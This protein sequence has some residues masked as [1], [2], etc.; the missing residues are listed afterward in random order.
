MYS[1]IKISFLEKL[2]CKYA[3]IVEISGVSESTKIECD[4]RDSHAL[5]LIDAFPFN[6]N[7]DRQYNVI[8]ITI[9]GLP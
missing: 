1:R 4:A 3:K 9:S 6:E 7:V 8:D 2:Q 5:W